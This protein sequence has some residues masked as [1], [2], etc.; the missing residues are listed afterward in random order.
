V[1]AFETKVNFIFFR[2][3]NFLILYKIFDIHDR[4]NFVRD[5][6]RDFFLKK[7]KNN[8]RILFFGKQILE[9]F[10]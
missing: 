4:Q 3:N 1:A 8:V 2:D 5:F 9:N 6:V 7:K 10:F